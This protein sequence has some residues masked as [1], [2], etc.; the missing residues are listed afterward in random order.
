[1]AEIGFAIQPHGTVT[2]F[3]VGTSIRSIIE[4]P[5]AK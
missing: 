4:K 3:D 5:Q 2:A 1:M